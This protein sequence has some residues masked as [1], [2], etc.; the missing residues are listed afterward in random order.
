LPISIFSGSAKRGKDTEVL[1]AI[2]SRQL[3]E[4]NHWIGFYL[5]SDIRIRK[6]DSLKEKNA[7][8]TFH[9][10]IDD[11]VTLEPTSIKE[12]ELEPEYQV[13]FNHR[14]NNFKTVYLVKFPAYGMESTPYITTPK[15]S[16]VLTVAGPVR[17]GTAVWNKKSCSQTILVGNHD[18]FYWV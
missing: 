11:K 14:F 15:P 12:V 17:E 3:E 8:W 10:T 4:T 7:A 16:L 18:D 9:L 6:H 2:E 13:L 5:L 1:K